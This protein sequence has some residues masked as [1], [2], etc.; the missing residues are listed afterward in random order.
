MWNRSLTVHAEAE[1]GHSRL[2]AAGSRVRGWVARLKP[3]LPRS[4]SA[5][6]VAV[7]A[8][9]VLAACSGQS[10]FR[11]DRSGSGAQGTEAS[12]ATGG[13]A[14]SA[15]QGGSSAMSSRGRTSSSCAVPGGLWDCRAHS[16]TSRQATRCVTRRSSTSRRD[17]RRSCGRRFEC[18]VKCSCPVATRCEPGTAWSTG[19]GHR[20]SWSVSLTPVTLRPSSAGCESSCG[21]TNGWEW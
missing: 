19:T 7:A 1:R 10:D 6:R 17:S 14:S 2:P 11:G 8:W 3:M 9:V 16:A 4:L 13:G 15:G 12:G 21:T 5:A 18:V 20:S